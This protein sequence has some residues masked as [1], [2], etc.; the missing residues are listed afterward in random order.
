M[1]T[2]IAP[3]LTE[4]LIQKLSY[5][6]A[7]LIEACMCLIILPTALVFR[8]PTIELDSDQS[9]DENKTEDKIETENKL[10]H[11]KTI[12]KSGEQSSTSLTAL[13]KD[14]SKFKFCSPT[15]KLHLKILK[16][17][18]FLL[19]LLYYF[20]GGGFS[21]V[22]Y[23]G[24]V[25]DYFIKVRNLLDFEQAA[26]G[27]TLAGVGSVVGSL[28]VT[29]LSHWSFD[30]VIFSASSTIVITLCV[31][32]TPI[33]QTVGEIYA[34]FITFGVAYG[35]YASGMASLVE[36]QFGQNSDFVI[37]Y[38]YVLFVLGIGGVVGPLLVGYVGTAVGMS[39]PFYFLG[40]SGMLVAAILIVYRIVVRVRTRAM[41][42]DA[43]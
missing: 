2:L 21:G 19:V 15:L 25:V 16:N 7:L 32:L 13:V 27:M 24:V 26:L 11:C 20:F 1:G 37:R 9:T 5:S 6:Y 22:T 40:G 34:V 14:E 30:R 18:V 42:V 43:Q 36:Y 41:V 33:A 28:L 35:T 8:A 4:Y 23:Y 3:I 17:P 29:L 38:S 10:E 39:Y 12:A 31:V